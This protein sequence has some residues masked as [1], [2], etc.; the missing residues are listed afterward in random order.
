VS[1]RAT[2]TCHCLQHSRTL[3]ASKYP[4]CPSLFFDM[5]NQ[6]KLLPISDLKVLV[7]FQPISD[8]DY[9][10]PTNWHM[11]P[12]PCNEK[13]TI[14][15]QAPLCGTK[16]HLLVT[17]PLLTCQSLNFQKPKFLRLLRVWSI[18]EALVSDSLS[19]VTFACASY[20]MAQVCVPHF[21]C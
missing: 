15:T 19:S 21:L 12:D 13:M 17:L 20:A 18:C 8:L 11:V 4:S 7:N 16:S 5:T 2:S 3:C 10:P 14:D 1:N 6:A 9:F